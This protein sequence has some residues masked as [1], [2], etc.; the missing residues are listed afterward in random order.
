[1]KCPKCQFDNTKDTLYCGKCGTRLPPS[2]EEPMSV[3]KTLETPL[4]ELAV[5]SEFAGRYQIVEDLG[6]GGMGRVYKALDR[7]IGERVA[8]KILKPEIAG[9]EQTIARFRN[10]LKTARQISH[11][12]VCR[13]YHLGREQG[14]PYI[15]MEYVSGEDLKST[16]TRVGQLSV[17][18][19]ISIISQVCEGLAEAHRLG[20]VHRDLKPQNI[21]IDRAGNA[22][23]M[24]FG[25]ARSVKGK[26]ITE[27]G[28]M[29][30]TPE[31]MSPEQVDGQEADKRADIYALGIIL[32]EL[33]T[34]RVPFE[35]DTP[36]SV[37]YK[38]KNET[39]PSALKINPQVPEDLEVLILKCLEKDKAKRY[40]DV[41]EVLADLAEI[42]KRLP[43][44]ERLV[45]RKKPLTSKQVTV[46]FPLR[47]ALVPGGIVVGVIV[48]ALVLWLA[49]PEKAQVKHSIAVI[50]FQNQTGDGAYDYLQEAIPNLLITSLE[51][52]KYLSVMTW[53]RM[54]D[55]LRQAGH[56]DSV[57]VDSDLG[58]EIC[59]RDGV[60]NIVLGSFIKAGEMFAT[61]VKVLD[62][63][64]KALLKSASS[65]GQGV[66]SILEKQIG[67]LSRE[68]ARG[69]GLS[70]RKTEA[71]RTR[72]AD[73]TT[74]SMEAYQYYLEAQ[75]Q[76]DKFYY[77]EARKLA[78]KA[79]DIDPQ[80]AIAYM[81][82]AYIASGLGDSGTR[83]RAFEKAHAL[84]AKASEKERLYIEANYAG[85]IEKDRAKEL[86]TLQELIQK[87]PKEKLAHYT[88]GQYYRS[89]SRLQEAV[90][91]FEKAVE[92]DPGY[93]LAL[94]QMAYTV[95]D[96]GDLEKAV[97]LFSRY[98]ALYP[99]DANPIDS[100]AEMYFRMG[101]LD[102]AISKY[103]EVINS[104][105]SFF[106]SYAGLVYVYSLKENYDEAL[107]WVDQFVS[108]APSA[109]L[110]GQ[111]YYYRSF[112]NFW[113][114]RY[115]QALVEADQLMTMASVAGE[116]DAATAIGLFK[117]WI[118]YGQGKEEASRPF[119]KQWYDHN[120]LDPIGKDGAQALYDF[121]DGY[122]DL[123]TG[124]LDE[125]KRKLADFQ[126]VL[127][128][129][130]NL[131]QPQVFRYLGR[132]FEGELF[133][134]L[135]SV[136][137]AIAVLEKAPSRGGPP[138]TQ[139]IVPLYVQPFPLDALARAYR[140]K[141]DLDKAIAEYERLT[142]FDPTRPERN[143]IHPKNHFRLAELYD[144]KGL[145]ARAVETY[146]KFLDIWKNADPD[147]PEVVKAKERLAALQG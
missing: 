7:E 16:V 3:T 72:I 121:Y 117:G 125:A 36:F 99:D 48:T 93:G 69:V 77:G 22:K 83:D 94:N 115:K 58:F 63:Q 108:I 88:L 70:V 91:E 33:L 80:F 24:D 35:G 32:F 27:A 90:E 5:G 105:P 78:E 113:C 15:T 136:D 68:I 38:Q 4:K 104:K 74:S 6:K 143:W 43:T 101:R 95:A 2:E 47:K 140:T 20:V 124:R 12:N 87:Y 134:H 92:L 30:G 44:T 62:V 116:K 18:K 135:G 137:K 45:V 66:G 89:Q 133:L 71:S 132:Q 86:A 102:D 146:R 11:K 25:I 26:G 1:M 147:I 142:T 53:E 42:E 40:Q 139:D 128:N 79:I 65:Q 112:V 21:M 55:V 28:V 126:S 8:L 9:D 19:T 107:K 111:G 98:A 14:T 13:M 85:V 122:V 127:P 106:S 76:Y 54:K 114:G 96:Q 100:M 34:G 103:R 29:I 52:S 49:W 41:T 84:S 75:E 131:R 64:T 60:D 119:F 23:I 31:Y 144:Q 61:D 120:A 130:G 67:E 50:G 51:Q 81:G 141:G 59:R 110:K 57:I 10:E 37:A 73:L 17:G 39:P 46:S 109:Q 123:A 56:E 97:E 129:S 118:L 82:L 145:R 138:A